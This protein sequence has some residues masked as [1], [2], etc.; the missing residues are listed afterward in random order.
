MEF[1]PLYCPLQHVNPQRVG[2][3]GDI[4]AGVPITF[5]GNCKQKHFPGHS[6]RIEFQ[7]DAFGNVSW[8]EMEKESDKEYSFGTIR[9]GVGG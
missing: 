6:G 2:Y 5:R 8:R 3:I 1:I 4:E 9:I 7:V